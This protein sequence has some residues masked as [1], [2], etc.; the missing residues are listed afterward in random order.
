MMSKM[1]E[2]MP[3]IMWILVGAFLATIVFSWGMGGFKGKQTLDGVV[4]VVGKH[5][6]LFDQY[7]R[8]VQDR[9]AQQRKT[10]D[11]PAPITDDMVRQARKDVWDDLVRTGL[12]EAYARRWGIVTSDEEVAFAVRNS[13]PK[14]IRENENF[15][16]D[17]QFDRERYEEFLRDPRSAQIL[18]SIENEYRAS[19]GNQKVIEH[20]IAPVFVGPDEVWD[21]YTAT[22]RKLNALVVSFPIQNFAVDSG[23]ITPAEIQKYYDQNRANYERKERCKLSYVTFPVEATLDDSNKVMEL[24]QEALNRARSGE[25][26]AAIAQELSEDP[27][28]AERGGDLGYFTQG[29]MVKEFDSVA[30]ATPPG[31]IA[32]P[33]VTRF[34][35][36]VIKVVDRKRAASGDSVR[37]SHILIKWKASPETDER[38]GQKAKDFADAAKAEGFANAAS[39][40]S[41]EVK[42]TDWF[43]RG[44]TTI[45]GI[46]ALSAATDFAFASKIGAISNLFRTKIRGVDNYVIFQVKDAQPKTYAPLAEVENAI[47]SALLR[48]KQGEMALETARAF[49][50]AVQD[51]ESFLAEAARRGMK[52]DTTG[53]HTQ[54]EYLGPIG[55]DES[56]GK[57]LLSLPIGQ[58]SEPICNNR[59]A[60][61]AVLLSKTEPDS[62]DFESKKAD[63]LQRLQR[64]KQNS[65]Y[66]DWLS[67]AQK[68][69]GVVDKRYLYYT[70]Y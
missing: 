26:F 44:A 28:S 38:V 55:S 20:V 52:V 57:Y 35:V 50:A 32:G 34:G 65:V 13:P 36:H 53:E 29:R 8:M 56:A 61:V 48:Q 47:R 9:L 31:Q 22:T 16:K 3:L 1:R 66:A 59:G 7:N 5:E 70:D 19:I 40:F 37:A 42:E 2:N 12:M 21:E 10:E 54:R 24:A 49:R 18:V 25:D 4:G 68:E 15:L 43:N 46:G 14:W 67:E 6:I 51:R 30:F 60:Y 62:S 41:L 23:S 63:I 27:G 11:K 45:P 64:N 33:V 58:V 39:R 69:V 17:G